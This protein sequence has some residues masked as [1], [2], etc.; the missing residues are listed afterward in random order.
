MLYYNRNRID[1]SK[2]IDLAK[3]NKSK[4]YMIYHYRFLIMDS[5]FQT[6]HGMVSMI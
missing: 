1:I 5:N 2:E 3:S 4:E 6:L